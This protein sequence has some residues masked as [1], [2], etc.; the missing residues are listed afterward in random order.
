MNRGDLLTGQWLSRIKG[1]GIPQ[2]NYRHT[3]NSLDTGL[4]E[5]GLL[6]PGFWCGETPTALH[7][8][9][10]RRLNRRGGAHDLTAHRIR[11][12]TRLRR[13]HLNLFTLIPGTFVPGN[14]GQ[15]PNTRHSITSTH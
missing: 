10:F 7:N 14:G 3:K 12:H 5:N 13:R 8:S 2:T 4:N 1:S 11:P 9:P 15:Q 6:T